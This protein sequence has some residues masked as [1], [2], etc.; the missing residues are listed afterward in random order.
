MKKTLDQ[1][2]SFKEAGYFH[3]QSENDKTFKRFLYFLFSVKEFD[4]RFDQS[5]RMQ[6]LILDSLFHILIL[7]IRAEIEGF[8]LFNAQ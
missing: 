3:F 2:N 7:T 8:R 1:K 4:V 5:E 6:F